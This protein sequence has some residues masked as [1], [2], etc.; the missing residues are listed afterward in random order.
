MPSPPVPAPKRPPARRRAVAGVPSK[1]RTPFSRQTRARPQ[2]RRAGS[3]IAPSWS[4]TAARKI[5]EST[6]ARTASR[7]R[8]SW[9][10]AGACGQLDLFLEALDLP[11]LGGDVDLAAVLPVAVDAVALDVGAHLVEVGDAGL[12]EA[13]EVVRP[14]REVVGE[15][16]RERGHAEA[17]VA[18]RGLPADATGL[19]DDDVERRVTL[20]GEQRRPE[21]GVA[22]ADDGEV[23]GDRAGQRRLA[24][25]AAGESSQNGVGERSSRARSG[26]AGSRSRGR[27]E[28]GA[29]V[30]IGAPVVE[31]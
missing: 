29:S 11:G 4:Q 12:R 3:S 9:C 30:C 27:A 2:A 31:G 28:R 26:Q 14:A 1:M 19:D 15:A 20:L 8:Y 13:L 5:G 18:A 21:A 6:S 7:S 24:A 10:G 17:A 25:G 23:A 16:V 22:A